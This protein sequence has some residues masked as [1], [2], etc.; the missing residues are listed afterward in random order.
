MT[1]GAGT[2]YERALIYEVLSRMDMFRELFLDN[3]SHL[4]EVFCADAKIA[5]KEHKTNMQDV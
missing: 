4:V 5:G 2:V 1:S 3:K